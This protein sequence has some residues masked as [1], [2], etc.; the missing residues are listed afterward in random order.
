MGAAGVVLAV[1]VPAASAL[2]ACTGAGGREGVLF[3]GAGIE[4]RAPFRVLRL[5]RPGRIA[6]DVATS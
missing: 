4:K 6:V 3:F 5:S 2:S 1:V